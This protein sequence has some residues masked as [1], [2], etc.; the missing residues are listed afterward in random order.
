[1]TEIQLEN[2]GISD[3]KPLE[4]MTRLVRLNL[5]NNKVKSMNVFTF[6]DSF[7]NLKWL[8]VRNNKLTE[9]PALRLPKLEYLDI[10]LNKMEKVNEGW[11][12]HPNIRILKSVDN[13][14][15]TLAPFK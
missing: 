12:G 6:E 2:N 15:K 5:A 11:A 8:D 10:S 4:C 7:P 9:I 14:F 1:M 13:K 3:L